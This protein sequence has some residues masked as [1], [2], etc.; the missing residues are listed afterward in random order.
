MI[1]LSESKID[2]NAPCWCGSG[3][4]Y[5]NC[6]M[7][8]DDKIRAIRLQG[9]SVPDRSLIKTA[10]QIEGIRRSA[11]VNMVCLDAVAQAI[12]AGMSTQEIDAAS[13]HRSTTRDSR[14]ASAPR[15]TRKSATAFRTKST[16]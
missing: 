7:E 15:S 1:R 12:H 3:K 4:K 16:S 9:H 6:H 14:R 2:R 11:K 5:K 10:E 13:P 8:F